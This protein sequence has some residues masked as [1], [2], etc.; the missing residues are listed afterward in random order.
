MRGGVKGRLKFTRKFTRFGSLTPK[1]A[2][3]KIETTF[4]AEKV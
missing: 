4:Y 2:Q 1:E 3:F